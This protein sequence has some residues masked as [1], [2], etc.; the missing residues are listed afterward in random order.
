M[1]PFFFMESDAKYLISS[2]QTT[3][4]DLF[5]Q[6]IALQAKVRQLSDMV[7]SLQQELEELKSKTKT[8][9]S[10]KTEGDGGTF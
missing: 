7:Q 3:S 4:A 6:S 5:T 1:S 8:P 2:Y 10:K 9:R